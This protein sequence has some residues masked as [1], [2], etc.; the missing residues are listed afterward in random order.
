MWR[1]RLSDI[2]VFDNE[3]QSTSATVTDFCRELR[4]QIKFVYVVHPPANGQAES[5][6]KVILKGIKNK[7]VMPRGCEPSY[8]MKILLYGADDMLLVKFDTPSWSCSQV[9]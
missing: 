8:S 7:F 9:N 6:N 3:T 2:I 5:A 4:V 1:L